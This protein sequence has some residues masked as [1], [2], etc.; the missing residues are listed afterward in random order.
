MKN[1]TLCSSCSGFLPHRA[2]SCPHCDAPVAQRSEGTGGAS[3][4]RKL[5]RA[6]AR[7]ATGGAVAATL[8]ACYG[9]PPS[10]YPDPKPQTMCDGGVDSDHDGVCTP[11]DC[12][13]QN[14]N[15]NPTASDPPGDGIDQNCDGADGKAP[16][17]PPPPG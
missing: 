12:N 3:R 5:G 9:G 1:L 15:V 7:V 14:T 10:D 6:I 11:L 2:T 13:D 17:Q 4:A 16:V 8:M